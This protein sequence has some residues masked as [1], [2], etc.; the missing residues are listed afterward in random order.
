MANQIRITPEQMR[1]R[2]TD[3]RNVKTNELAAL[4]KR[5]DNLLATLQQEW[6]GEAA[7]AY[8]DRWN[9]TVKP[10]VKNKMNTLLDEIAASLDKTARILEDTD[11]QIA[12]AFKG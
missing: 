5:M 10:D 3:Y 7:R 12:G 8:A 11:A 6:E 1:R 9:G 2:A 4:I